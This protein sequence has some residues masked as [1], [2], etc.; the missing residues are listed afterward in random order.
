LTNLPKVAEDINTFY[1]PHLSASPSSST[2]PPNKKAK[3]SKKAKKA[4]GKIDALPDWM[5]TYDS[6]SSSEDESTPT[7]GKKRIRTSQLSI[8]QSIH[9]VPSHI[10]SY[11]SLW[12][13]ILSKVELEE[14]WTR[15]ILVGLH[16]EKGILGHMKP[17]RRVR[18]AD[19][20]GGL[21]DRG[22]V[23][24]VLAMNGLYVL[25]TKYNL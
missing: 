18:V 4:P 11:T 14:Y 19:W 8:H 22:G 2:L 25:M 24:A 9:S 20:L 12:E 5:A 6:P 3:L 23:E 21:V 15:R 17:E 7:N 16:G 13:T 1:I 10:A